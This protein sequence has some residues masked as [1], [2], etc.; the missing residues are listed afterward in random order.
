VLEDI[1]GGTHGWARW[2]RLRGIIDHV[3][4]WK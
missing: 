1:L 3:Q 4:D 2:P